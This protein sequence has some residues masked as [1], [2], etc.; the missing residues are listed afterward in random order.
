M[1]TTVAAQAAAAW[2][3]RLTADAGL[4]QASWAQLADDLKRQDVVFGGRPLCTVLR[5]R[6]FAP[7]E[8]DRYRTQA[9]A[10]LSAFR[11]A[12]ARAVADPAARAQFLLEEWEESLF[13]ASAAQHADA[14][15][16]PL[17]RLDTFASPDGQGFSVTEYNGETPAG[18]FYND[19]IAAAFEQLPITRV[20][21][22]DWWLRPLPAGA[23]T[24][25]PLLDAWERFRGVRSVPRVAILDWP[26][27]P[28]QS[29]FRLAQA[30]FRAR[31]IPCEI[32]DPRECEFAGGVLR[33]HGAPVDVVYKRVLFEE[34]VTRAGIDTPV[35]QAMRAGAVLMV[36]GPR[37][38]LLHKK[39]SLAVLSDE[40]NASWFDTAMHAAIRAHIP[41]TRVVEARR[42]RG[43]DGPEVDLLPWCAGNR[44]RLVIKP[45]DA[46]G[47]HGIVLGWTVDATT[48]NAALATAVSTPT[49]VQQRVSI[50]REVYPSIEGGALAL[51]ERQVDTAPYVIDGRW[52]EGALSRLSTAEL[53]NVTAGGGS[54]TP[55]FLVDRR[56]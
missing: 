16:E 55:T 52:V 51:I 46:Y 5:P 40:R 20:M 45:S 42:T 1:S 29:E 11:A 39:T 15:Y 34:L 54:Q 19:A 6:L 28:T 30:Q 41:W 17:G 37:G 47:G 27:V 26:E 22:R 14:P 4:A 21:A 48:W 32:G 25:R 53:L 50:P 2:H 7:D 23:G 56:P 18:P 9:S 49:I 31:G 12:K 35:L 13:V 33:L 10:L 24:I 3:E 36:N 44:D 43:P 8:W 38:K